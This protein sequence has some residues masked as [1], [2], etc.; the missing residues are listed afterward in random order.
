MRM[1]EIE[2]FL[3][4]EMAGHFLEDDADIRSVKRFTYRITDPMTEDEWSNVPKKYKTDIGEYECAIIASGV[5]TFHACLKA[6]ERSHRKGLIFDLFDLWPIL[7]KM[8]KDVW[9]KRR[10]YRDRD[11]MPQH[12]F[13]LLLG[14]S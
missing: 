10:E 12:Y 1:T 7:G 9:K 14:F 8:D 2:N 11:E 5:T 4:Y 3:K 13:Q 6:L